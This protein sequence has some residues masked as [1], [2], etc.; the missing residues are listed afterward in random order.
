M[1]NASIREYVI[2][3]QVCDKDQNDDITALQKGQKMADEG[4]E[5]LS[6]SVERSKVFFSGIVDAEMRKQVSYNIKF[7]VEE[8]TGEIIHSE[9]ECPAGKGPNATCKHIVGALLV[10]SV[11]REKGEVSL[12][13]SCTDQLQTFKRPR[14]LYTGA[15]VPAE[16]LSQ[17]EID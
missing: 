17:G 3:R 9:C 15:P 5:A 12:S 10:V 4:V 14:K 16:E 13:G 6:F 11:L 1:T 7:A 8:D 2:Y